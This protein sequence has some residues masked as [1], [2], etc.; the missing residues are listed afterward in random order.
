MG[1]C[2]RRTFLKGTA[3]VLCVSPLLGAAAD[4][5]DLVVGQLKTS[6]NWNPRPNG[7]RRLLWE[8]AQRTSIE[9]SLD[10]T[11]LEPG[12]GAVF[13]HP[14]LY[15]SGSGTAGLFSED[16][17]KRL[18]RHLTYGGTLLID[19]ADADPGGPFDSSVRRELRRILPREKLQQ[20]PNEHVIYKSFFLVDYQAGRTIRVPYLEGVAIE[21]RMA[22][23]YCQ[24]D[25][26]GAWSRDSF[27]RW[28]FE[29]TPGGER[30]REMAFRLGINLVMY[31][32]CL[33]YKDDQVHVPFI[34]KRRR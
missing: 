10:P 18:R 13:R 24:N 21:K 11:T 4:A 6:G 17:V 28:E 14:F 8:V 20:I 27:G 1:P 2:D 31:A 16:A 19:S 5:S 26:A 29:V 3:A 7:I 23:I 32:M 30:Q 25:L 15:W 9:V 33:D 22:V 12:D 34:V